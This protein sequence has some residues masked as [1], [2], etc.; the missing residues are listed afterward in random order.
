MVGCD[1]IEQSRANYFSKFQHR[2]RF[3]DT[4]PTHGLHPDFSSSEKEKPYTSPVN[5]FAPNSYGLH[6]MAGN[7]W[8]WCWDWLSN[9]YYSSSLVG[10]IRVVLRQAPTG[11]CG[12]AVGA[13]F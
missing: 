4:S 8:E 13:G 7:L 12:A 9:T 5:Y 3:S 2:T 6:D 11:W 1:T 10:R